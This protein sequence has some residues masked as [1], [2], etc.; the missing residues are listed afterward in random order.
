MSNQ[1]NQPTIINIDDHQINST[2]STQTTHAT[3]A[4]RAIAL[5]VINTTLNNTQQADFRKHIIQTYIQP[6]YIKDIKD[7][8]AGRYKWRKISDK[9]TGISKIIIVVSGIF[10]FAGAKFTDI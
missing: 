4:T 6:T 9:I 5:D 3:Q 2:E 7:S 10:A 1:N 8:L